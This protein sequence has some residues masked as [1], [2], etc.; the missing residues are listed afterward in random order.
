M[1]LQIVVDDVAVHLNEA[2]IQDFEN[3][4]EDTSE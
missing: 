1:C 3:V 4:R 2:Q